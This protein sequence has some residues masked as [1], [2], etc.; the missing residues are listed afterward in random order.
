MSATPFMVEPPTHLVGCIVDAKETVDALVA[1]FTAAGYSGEKSVYV[2]HGEEALKRLDPDGI[3]HGRMAHFMRVF[4]K[5]TT[6]VDD[7]LFNAMKE[8]LTQ[9]HYLVGVMTD[10]GDEQRG[11]VHTIMKHHDGSRIFYSG[12]GAIQLMSGW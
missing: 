4:Q 7:R 6:G 3:Y 10:G 11:E 12:V 2:F 9:G 1:D 5:F 8:N